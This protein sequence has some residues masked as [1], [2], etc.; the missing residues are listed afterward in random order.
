[1]GPEYLYA[2]I[3]EPEDILGIYDPLKERCRL[4]EITPMGFP[5]RRLFQNVI[6]S[7]DRVCLIVRHFTFHRQNDGVLKTAGNVHFLRAGLGGKARLVR[8]LFQFQ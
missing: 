3:Q 7:F 5:C 4:D 1:M 2:R 6:D 8:K